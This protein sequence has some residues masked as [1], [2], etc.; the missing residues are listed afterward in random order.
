MPASHTLL[1]SLRDFFF[2]AGVALAGAFCYFT[3][4]EYSSVMSWLLGA[5]AV[6]AVMAAEYCHAG[7]TETIR[8]MDVKKIN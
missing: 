2:W 1:R 4:I 8:N 5:G 7:V 3:I 6:F